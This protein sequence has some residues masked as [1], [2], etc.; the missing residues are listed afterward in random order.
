M[1]SYKTSV[2]SYVQSK[3]NQEKIGCKQYE[4]TS[5]QSLYV[6]GVSITYRANLYKLFALYNCVHKSSLEWLYARLLNVVPKNNTGSYLGAEIYLNF[7][8]FKYIN[9]THTNVLM[10]TRLFSLHLKAYVNSIFNRSI[11]VSN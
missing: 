9:S 4:E 3:V 6:Y 11:V 8:S 2:Q 5:N 1:L 10:F 7:L